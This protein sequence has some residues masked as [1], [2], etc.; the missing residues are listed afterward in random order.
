VSL[1]SIPLVTNSVEDVFAQLV[2]LGKGF[3]WALTPFDDNAKLIVHIASN[4]AW[5]TSPVLRTQ[6]HRPMPPV[7][8]SDPKFATAQADSLK[9]RPDNRTVFVVHGRDERLRA[10]LFD[11][12]RSI[13]LRP[14][15][16]TEAV[17]LTG[18]ASPYIGEIL[19][20]AFSYAQAVVVLLTPDDEARLREGLRGEHEQA[21]E[22]ELTPQARPNVLFE[23]GMAMAGNPDR[24][25]LVQIGYL[26]P[27]SDIA[28]RHTILM[29][30][31]TKKRYDLV[32]RLQSAGCA[33]N[34]SGTDWQN[35]GDLTPPPEEI[36]PPSQNSTPSPE[37]T[38]AKA[39]KSKF[40]KFGR[41]FIAPVSRTTSDKEYTLQEVDEAGAVIRLPDG[42]LVR[43]PK[44]DYLESWDD[45]MGKPKLILT[46]KYFQGYFPG[47]ENAEEFFLPR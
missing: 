45:A 47:H 15:E 26:R 39:E 20:T 8:T 25:I 1:A 42:I 29:D 24:T 17:K 19:D 22:K 43:I 36:A 40:A 11:F 10:G 32:G 13:D 46:R 27:F 30:N 14:L 5:F 41:V 6:V 37:E 44:G 16:W 33:V 38:K 12:L 31:S 3:V 23:A 34:V 9:A 7:S 21:Y 4:L 28:G 2:P 35:A 18:K